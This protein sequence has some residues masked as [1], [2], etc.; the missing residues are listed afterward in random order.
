MFESARLKLTA[1]YL[2]IIMGISIVFS[3]AI[4]HQ[5]DQELNQLEIAR[6]IRQQNLRQEFQIFGIPPP[7]SEIDDSLEAIYA[8]RRRL[9]LQLI[10]INS[11]ILIIS[12]GA[13]Y[14]LAGRTL[15]P[16]QDM[17]D[18]Q[19][20]FVT[21]ASHELRTPLTSLRT[22]LEV[23]LREKKLTSDQ[24]K[25]ILRS[26]LEEV[27]RMQTLSDD[28]IL[29]AQYQ[30]VKDPTVTSYPIK[31]IIE[32][33][34]THVSALAKSKDIKITVL[35][36]DMLIMGDRK[37][38]QKLFVIFLDNAIKYSPEGS[39][40]TVEIKRKDGKIY[41][42]FADEGI[43]IEK[44]DIPHVFERFYRAEKSRSRNATGG[45]GL[46]LSIAKK[47]V[48]TYH[49][50][51]SLKSEKDRGTTFTISL[52]ETQEEKPIHPWKTKVRSFI[53]M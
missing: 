12:G 47:I 18:E 2:V 22:S 19:H 16:I 9:I 40:V 38:F 34:I 48:D 42:Q 39:K 14:F 44:S 51:I 43:G 24:S 27:H 4:Y 15:K 26:N 8:A 53:E 20:R 35:G 5:I 32:Q 37:S 7:L 45:Y 52:P 36:E 1:W 25:D 28:L 29:L 13:G 33:A 21:D 17:L 31:E 30:K 50:D 46:G 3:Y 11:G 10:I 49:G 6:Q 41:I 23:N